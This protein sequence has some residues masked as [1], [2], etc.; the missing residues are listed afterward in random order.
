MIAN[1][2]KGTVWH[3]GT[4]KNIRK[5]IFALLTESSLLCHWYSTVPHMCRLN[6]A[7]PWSRSCRGGVFFLFA[8]SHCLENLLDLPTTLL[9]LINIH[10]FYLFIA[11]SP[12]Y[13]LNICETIQFRIVTF[14]EILR[15]IYILY[16]PCYW[17]LKLKCFHRY[18][19]IYG[20]AT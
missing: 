6:S 10:M 2:L 16:R 12:S 1:N 17:Y 15:F 18:K 7:L 9:L 11:P 5:A 19:V 3:R 20:S 4:A 13:I 14:Y 8:C